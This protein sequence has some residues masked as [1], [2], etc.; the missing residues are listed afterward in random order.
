MRILG[1]DVGSKRIGA[2]LSDEMGWTAQGKTVLVRKGISE[3]IRAIS[4]L[5][6]EH[7]AEEIVVGLPLNMNGSIG[8]GGKEV[9]ALIEK[10]KSRI[11]LPIKVWDERLTTVAA[12]KTLI[13]ANLSRKRRRKVIDKLAAVLILQGYLDHQK[14]GGTDKNED[15][16]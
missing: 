16:E 14:G 12:E 13:E 11:D 10:L 8:R 5:A 4:Q 6:S 2:A 15:E 9:L 7:R 1:L 3:D